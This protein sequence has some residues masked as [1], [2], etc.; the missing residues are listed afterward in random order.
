MKKMLAILLVLV[1]IAALFSGCKPEPDLK[2]FTDWLSTSGFSGGMGKTLFSNHISQY[3]YQGAPLKQKSEFYDV[4]GGEGYIVGTDVWKWTH[5]T[6]ENGTKVNNNFTIKA[7]LDGLSLPGGVKMGESRDTCMEKLGLKGKRSD[8]KDVKAGRG[9]CDLTVTDTIITFKEHYDWYNDAG[10][11][12]KVTR[13][14]MFK[15]TNG[16]LTEFS[17]IVTDVG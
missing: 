3:Y 8:M 5:E 14:L 12:I 16:N 10:K 6:T 1:T 11:I 2:L 17:I 15:F 4:S 13:T 9:T 7:D